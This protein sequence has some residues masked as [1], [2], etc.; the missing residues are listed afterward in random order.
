MVNNWWL[1]LLRGMVA[2]IFGCIAFYMPGVTL[3][4]LTL[5]WAFM[6][7]STACWPCDQPYQPKAP[8]R[9]RVGGLPPSTLSVSSLVWR[10]LPG[11]AQPL[12]CR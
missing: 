3:L 12:L 7:L 1:L 11:P 10:P 4:S 5:V 9:L 6:P 2:I 8:A